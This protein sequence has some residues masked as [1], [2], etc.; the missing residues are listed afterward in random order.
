MSI[1]QNIRN[2]RESH[3]LSQTE[4][5]KIAGVTDKAVSTW[6]IDAKIPRMGA[7]QK[8]AEYF[9]VPKSTI[10][11]DETYAVPVVMGLSP[12]LRALEAAINQLNEEGCE[13]LLDYADD[14]VR[15]GKYKK[16]N[17]NSVGKK[18]A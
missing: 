16:Y 5:G 12:E 2:L 14:L 15:S 10:L 3:G 9:H 6:E 11:D 13:K 4:L 1:G 18:E 8:M 17:S 7:V